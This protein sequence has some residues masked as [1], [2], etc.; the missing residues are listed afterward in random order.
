MSITSPTRRRERRAPRVARAGSSW[1]VEHDDHVAS[2]GHRVYVVAYH[3][4][5]D[6]ARA[7]R[8]GVVL[9]WADHHDAPERVRLEAPGPGDWFVSVLERYWHPS[10]YTFRVGADVVPL[11]RL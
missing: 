7:Q 4:S 10:G 2:P 11:R 5:V 9:T 6:D 3:R 8:D 1:L